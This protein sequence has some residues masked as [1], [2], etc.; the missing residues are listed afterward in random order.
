[1]HTAL[2]VV[3]FAVLHVLLSPWVDKEHSA[4][5]GLPPLILLAAHDWVNVVG[6]ARRE[7]VADAGE[8]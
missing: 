7:R 1:M 4:I 5:L 6:R 8:S 2:L 3:L